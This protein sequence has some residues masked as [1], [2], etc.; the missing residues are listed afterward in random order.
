MRCRPLDQFRERSP[1]LNVQ[2]H[3]FSP[4]HL[5]PTPL[6]PGEGIPRLSH[7]KGSLIYNAIVT[8]E[9]GREEQARI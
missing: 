2:A 9:R 8:S 4:E 3:D 5:T 6:L 1:R 7:L